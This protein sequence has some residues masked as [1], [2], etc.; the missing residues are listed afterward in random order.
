MNKPQHIEHKDINTILYNLK[1]LNASKIV[2]SIY[3]LDLNTLIK[4]K[5][6]LSF[7]SYFIY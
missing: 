7:N 4:F 1:V 3:L 5:L 2:K 6:F